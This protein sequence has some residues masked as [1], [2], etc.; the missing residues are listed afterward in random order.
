MLMRTD[1]FRELDRL[2]QQLTGASGTWSKPSAMPMDAWREG[3]EYVIALDLPGVAKDAIDVDV[4]RNMLT[5][6]AERRPVVTGEDVQVELSERPLGAFSRQLVLADTLDTERIRAD[7]DA[8]V[9]TLRIPIAERAK[10][11]KIAIGD[12]P[13]HRQIDT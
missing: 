5:V 6:K 1:P 8:G 11:R 4:E 13:H 9:L 7:Y 10:P 2:A 3:E 12:M